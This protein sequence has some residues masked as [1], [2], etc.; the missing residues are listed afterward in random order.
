MTADIKTTVKTPG[1]G[2]LNYI[3]AS[4]GA[5][6]AMRALGQQA[7]KSG[8]DDTLLE[9]LSLR[10]SQLNGCGFCI[11]MHTKELRAAGVS[12]QKLYLLSVWR[13][14]ELYSPRERAALAWTEALTRL[15]EGCVPDDVYREAKAQF[16]EA[17]LVDLTISVNEINGWN[18]L[19]IAFQA[20]AGHYRVGSLK[21]KSA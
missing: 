19:N 15:G 18:R 16:S 11:D 20:E 1:F 14:T 13:E 5:L 6:Q 17:E 9:L 8:L 21:T 12:E 2:R 3:A 10:A 4:P 7:R